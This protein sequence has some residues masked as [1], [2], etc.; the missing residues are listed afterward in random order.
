M[1]NVIKTSEKIEVKLETRGSGAVEKVQQQ[2]L[3]LPR[4]FAPRNNIFFCIPSFVW[5]VQKKHF[6]GVIEP[7]DC[8]QGGQNFFNFGPFFLFNFV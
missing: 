6:F 2:R 7:F 1:K 3:R 8:A 4:R 5:V